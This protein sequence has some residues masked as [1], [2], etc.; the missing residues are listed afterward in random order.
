MS[1]NSPTEVGSVA[2]GHTE[3]VGK[4]KM[5]SY[6]DAALLGRLAMESTEVVNVTAF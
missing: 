3:V 1:P 4:D 2:E 6:V 5:Q